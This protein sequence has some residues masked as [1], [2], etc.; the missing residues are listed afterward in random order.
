MVREAHGR[1]LRSEIYRK[2]LDA[3][4][5]LAK[6]MLDELEECDA[7]VAS[8]WKF[9]SRHSEVNYEDTLGVKVPRARMTIRRH[10]GFDKELEGPRD[11]ILEDIGKIKE[12]MAKIKSRGRD[13]L[14]RR[15]GSKFT[16]KI[17]NKH[18]MAKFRMPMTIECHEDRDPVEH[19]GHFET[20]ME[21]QAQHQ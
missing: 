11:V 16:K 5:K 13:P 17:A 7:S 1:S 9:Q 8:P 2:T 18:S 12:D 20:L 3:L 21:T 15:I 19:V 14:A 4:M 6:E 10:L